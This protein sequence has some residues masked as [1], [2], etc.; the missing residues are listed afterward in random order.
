MAKMIMRLHAPTKLYT[1][2][3]GREFDRGYLDDSKHKCI[4]CFFK[5]EIAGLFD[6][7]PDDK[8]YLRV[9]KG[10]DGFSV[11]LVR[12]K[13]KDEKE[14]IFDEVIIPTKKSINEAF[15]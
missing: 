1:C 12:P 10:P 6:L 7:H 8:K 5:E 15:N 2:V 13:T 14:K 9:W 11:K 4:F 3:C